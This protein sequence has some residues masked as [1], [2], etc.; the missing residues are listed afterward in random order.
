LGKYRVPLF[1]G[2]ELYAC[3]TRDAN[4]DYT[5]STGEVIMNKN[6]PSLWGIKNLSGEPWYMTPESGEGKNI[7][8]GA[9]VPIASNLSV[10][11]KGVTGKI[12]KE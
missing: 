11:F 7:D 5:T 4:D 2:V 6:N 8:D 9:I 3:H 10:Q 1:P 12:I